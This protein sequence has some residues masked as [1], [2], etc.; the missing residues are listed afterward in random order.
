LAYAGRIGTGFNDTILRDLM[1]RLLP[2]R[3]SKSPFV[4]MPKGIRLGDVTWVCPELVG[5]V[6]FSN[7]TD[8]GLLRQ[9]SFQ[10]LRED[11]PARDVRREVAKSSPI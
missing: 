2:L 8:E 9:A 10:G 5:Q 6:E 11:K 7:W 3:Q 4:E 1:R